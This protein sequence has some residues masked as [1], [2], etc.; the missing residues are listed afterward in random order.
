MRLRCSRAAVAVAAVA[1][2]PADVDQDDVEVDEEGD[3]GPRGVD[4]QTVV[5]ERL[6]VPILPGCGR[7]ISKLCQVVPGKNNT[8]TQ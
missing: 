8:D 4:G 2:Y 6:D 7:G 3:D 5:D 1:T